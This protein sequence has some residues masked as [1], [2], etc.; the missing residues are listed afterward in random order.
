M[1]D[2]NASPF[3]CSGC[4]REVESRSLVRWYRPALNYWPC[5]CGLT[6]VWHGDASDVAEDFDF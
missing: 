4:G 2:R 6:I 5:V 1:T 3:C